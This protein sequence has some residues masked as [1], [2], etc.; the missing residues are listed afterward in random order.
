[1]GGLPDDFITNL[2]PVGEGYVGAYYIKRN[3]RQASILET[4]YK[5]E[6][7]KNYGTVSLV[8]LVKQRTLLCI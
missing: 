1:M 4:M 8:H 2:W 6:Q 3:I 5:R 7:M